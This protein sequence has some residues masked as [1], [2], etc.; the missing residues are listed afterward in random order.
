MSIENIRAPQRNS[1]IVLGWVSVTSVFSPFLATESTEKK[2]RVATRSRRYL[3]GGVRSPVEK[4][5]LTSAL[6]TLP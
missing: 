3:N 5:R 6:M 4:L 2:D 1:P